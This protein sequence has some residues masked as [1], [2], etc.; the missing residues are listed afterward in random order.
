[1]VLTVPTVNARLLVLDL[2]SQTPL[3]SRDEAEFSGQAILN[4]EQIR[5]VDRAT[6][7][8]REPNEQVTPADPLLNDR[9]DPPGGEYWYGLTRDA[10]KNLVTEWIRFKPGDPNGASEKLS[11]SYRLLSAQLSDHT[12]AQRHFVFVRPTG[13]IGNQTEAVVLNAAEGTHTVVDFGQRDAD[14]ILA[15]RVSGTD[16]I[17]IERVSGEIRASRID[18]SPVVAE[19]LLTGAL[20]DTNASQTAFVGDRHIMVRAV[21]TDGTGELVDLYSDDGATWA[22]KRDVFDTA[23]LRSAADGGPARRFGIGPAQVGFVD[24]ET[25][26]VIVPGDVCLRV[27]LRAR[28]KPILENDPL[29]KLASVVPMSLQAAVVPPN[30]FVGLPAG[31]QVKLNDETQRAED[32]PLD[33]KEQGYAF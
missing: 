8:L 15:A 30:V 25:G 23:G 16:T 11:A 27:G 1:L 28:P 10:D 12:R 7:R 19:P 6:G 18:R 5:V 2:P 9:L 32:P 22:V 3:D 13:V 4:G 29:P 17:I 14:G 31:I 33:C 20:A 26:A 24:A 21:A